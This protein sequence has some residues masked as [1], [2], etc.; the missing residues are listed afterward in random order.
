LTNEGDATHLGLET[1]WGV[2]CHGCP[3]LA[4][5]HCQSTLNEFMRVDVLGALFMAK[6]FTELGGR[7]RTANDAK[8]TD[9]AY[10]SMVLRIRPTARPSISKGSPGS[11][12]MVW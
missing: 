7:N 4:I 6:A 12:K 8:V 3:G 5:S 10:I 11:T 2:G 9:Q 1:G